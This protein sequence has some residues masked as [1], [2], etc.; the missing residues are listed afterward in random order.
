MQKKIVISPGGAR[1][2]RSVAPRS[3][4]TATTV[5][6]GT[7]RAS[8]S[9]ARWRFSVACAATWRSI[10]AMRRP[11]NDTGSARNQFAEGAAHG[12]IET[13]LPLTVLPLVDSGPCCIMGLARSQ[14]PVNGVPTKWFT[15]VH[16]PHRITGTGLF[17]VQ[18][19]SCTAHKGAG[20]AESPKRREASRKERLSCRFPDDIRA[21]LRLLDNTLDFPRR[22]A[23]LFRDFGEGCRRYQEDQR[24]EMDLCVGAGIAFRALGSGKSTTR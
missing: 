2:R 4:R 21:Q 16:W 14:S 20:Y 19:H 17:Q 5:A 7:A 13:V 9:R 1:V 12:L 23:I 24:G 18:H 11:N 22:S 10:R 3:A 8:A 6:I 15:P